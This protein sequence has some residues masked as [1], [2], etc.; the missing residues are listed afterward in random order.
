M[1]FGGG[2]RE[3]MLSSE[4][5]N[6]PMSKRYRAKL[7]QQNKHLFGQGSL[8]SLPKSTIFHMNHSETSGFIRG[9]PERLIGGQKSTDR[10]QGGGEFCVAHVWH[11]LHI[12]HV[13]FLFLFR[14]FSGC[15]P[16]HFGA[17]FP[18]TVSPGH[19][20]AA[21]ARLCAAGA[22]QRGATRLR[23]LR[24][25]PPGGPGPVG[26]GRGGV[27]AAIR[28]RLRVRRSGGRRDPLA[29]R[30]G[31]GEGRAEG[32]STA[33]GRSSLVC[34][35]VP[36]FFFVLVDLLSYFFL[37]PVPP[38]RATVFVAPVQNPHVVPR[39]VR[40]SPGTSHGVPGTNTCV[41]HGAPTACPP[42]RHRF[43]RNLTSLALLDPCREG[44][45]Q[46]P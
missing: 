6:N 30:R 40:P 13:S 29:A 20:R 39:L 46:L 9:F 45:D 11:T 25:P 3:M 1:C 34:H 10:P 33:C 23:P 43:D 8:I 31:P 17:Y 16:V 36:L 4:S 22:G 38:L 44:L 18:L 41:V 21:A 32:H 5:K 26:G 14:T 2:L 42:L 37:L 12:S 19:E 35:E 24:Q 7:V 15:F 27:P 28:R